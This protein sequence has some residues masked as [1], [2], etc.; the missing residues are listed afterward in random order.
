MSLVNA[1]VSYKRGLFTIHRKK[2]SNWKGHNMNPGFSVTITYSDGEVQDP[3]GSSQLLHETTIG[4]DIIGI[5]RDFQLTP[6]LTRL[7]RDNHG[8][9]T[10]EVRKVK[11][12][13]QAYQAH[14]RDEA[15]RKDATLSY[16]FFINVYDNP[17]LKKKELEPLLMAT[18]GNPKMRHP[19]PQMTEAIEFLY[20]RMG[21]VNRTRCHQW[22]YLFWDDLYRKNHEEIPQLVPKEFSPA[23]PGSICYRPMARPELEKFLERHGCWQKN[24]R[25]GF[26][27][28]GVLNK[29]YTFL[30]ELVFEKMNKDQRQKQLELST[31]ERQRLE[32]LFWVTKARIHQDGTYKRMPRLDEYYDDDNNINNNNDDAEKG[33]RINNDDGGGLGRKPSKGASPTLTRKKSKK[34]W[35]ESITPG[36]LKSK[37]SS[38]THF[39]SYSPGYIIPQTW[40][41]KASQFAALLIGGRQE[42]LIGGSD[43]EDD[44]EDHSGGSSD[45]LALKRRKTTSSNSVDTLLVSASASAAEGGHDESSHDRK[46]SKSYPTAVE[47]QTLPPYDNQ[48]RERPP[49]LHKDYQAPWISVSR[50]GGSD[51]GGGDPAAAAFDN[52]ELVPLKA[53]QSLEDEPDPG[54][55]SDTSITSMSS[56]DYW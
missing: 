11:K 16:D 39:E 5:T 56:E 44:L 28:V 33:T 36:R 18:E 55:E 21:V 20:E 29:M 52:E 2:M 43:E 54:M 17:T 31:V 32:H 13:M 19:T 51:G 48:Q 22:W 14:Y 42:D 27:H 53:R 37:Q 12:V 50:E 26:M 38:G 24:G 23:F 9:I 10:R 1:P 45:H 34:G 46:K 25:G 8:L 40:Q 7:L 6:A 49:A 35:F 3:E 4:H 41:Q 47:L 15:L 30:N